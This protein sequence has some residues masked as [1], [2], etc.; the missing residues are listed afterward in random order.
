M[1]ARSIHHW[2]TS[3]ALA[4]VAACDSATVP[5]PDQGEFVGRWGARLWLGD[6][7]ASLSTG[8]PGGDVLHVFGIRPRGANGWSADETLSARVVFSGPGLYTLGPD[9]VRLLELVGGDVVS[10]EYKGSGEPAGFLSITRYDQSTRAIEGE[11]RFS[12]ETTSPYASY[13]STARFEDGK[14]R[15]V[16]TIYPVNA[17]R[18]SP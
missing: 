13:G 14:F 2:L 6:A 9:D 3:L 10:A 1:R 18:A 17:R 15:A 16:V 7:R 4:L 12:A 8:V 11:L 5:D